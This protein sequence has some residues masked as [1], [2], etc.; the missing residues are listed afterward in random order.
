[1]KIHNIK[2][3][4]GFTPSVDFGDA[5]N[6]R[7]KGTSPKFTAGFTLIETMIAV[8][9]LV[10]A[11]NAMLGL[12]STSL[13]SARYAKNE[14]TANYLIQEAIDYVRNDRDTTAFQKASDVDGGWANFQTK[15]QACFNPL[16][17]Q[18]EPAQTSSNI[19]A[20]TG[21][22]GGG[23]GTIGCSVFN[24]DQSATN[25]DF[26]TYDISQGV[27]SNF[28]RKINMSVNPNINS[29]DEIDMIVSVEWLN[30]T[31]VRSKYSRVSLLNWQK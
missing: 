8:F 24:F 13:F 20:C 1:M 18:I 26:Y 7:A 10:V 11:M 15:Y 29:Q 17:C 5:N 4:K 22:I 31:L 21:T 19:S 23:F 25:K 3:N 27:P 2:K 9:I 14:I 16:G 28:K 6:L 30:G 12:I